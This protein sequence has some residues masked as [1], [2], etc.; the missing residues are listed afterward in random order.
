MGFSGSDSDNL[1]PQEGVGSTDQDGPE[2]SEPAQRSRNV[3]VLDERA[4][5]ML[6]RANSVDLLVALQNCGDTYPVTEP[7][8]VMGRSPT[9]IDNETN[10]NETD[11]S[12][13]LDRCKPKL[14]FTESPSAQKVDDE[15]DKAGNGNPY[16]IV[17]FAVPVCK[18]Q[19][20]PSI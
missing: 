6:H 20:T 15:D 16:S 13:D 7:E 17:Y 9:Q 10:D 18:C 3:V 2:T 12:H 19:S 11:D 1:G 8:P 14:A 4:G 5:V